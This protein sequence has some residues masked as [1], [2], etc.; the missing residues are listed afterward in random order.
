MESEPIRLFTIGHSNHLLEKFVRLLQANDIQVLVDVRS[1][2]YSKYNPHFNMEELSTQLLKIEIRY[3]YAGKE[4]GG[5]PADPTCYKTNQIRDAATDY[6]HEVNYP[7]VMKR[8]WFQQG[9]DH[10]LELA[11][12]STTCIM[13]SEEDP[14][15]CHRHH[16][17]AK[18]LMENHPEV[19][20]WH[21]RG[22]GNLV[23]ASQIRTTVDEP[24]S[25][26]LSL[27]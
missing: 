19:E 26:Q 9:I 24:P 15:H 11:A 17:I 20:V 23:K 25:E 22:D 18:Y 27:F 6:L 14:A 10:L 21:I 16:L 7:E 5:R 8:N 12:R 4:L 13:C 2:P 1:A 3:V